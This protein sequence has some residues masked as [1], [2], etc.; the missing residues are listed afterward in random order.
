[1]TAATVTGSFDLSLLSLDE[2]LAGI[3]S[4][5]GLKA[6]GLGVTEG[7][8]VP[9]V[10]KV[11][12]PRVDQVAV[13]MDAA[14]NR[15][16]LPLV[17]R[18]E[19]RRRAM[20]AAAADSVR[21]SEAAWSNEGWEEYT[22][23][24]YRTNIVAL[25]A[26]NCI[27][28]YHD[29]NV[30]HYE[31]DSIVHEFDEFIMLKDFLQ[32]SAAPKFEAGCHVFAEYFATLA[33][34]GVAG[35]INW[36]RAGHHLGV[37]CTAGVPL[38][39]SWAGK[40]LERFMAATSATT[41]FRQHA[42]D[43]LWSACHVWPTHGIWGAIAATKFEGKNLADVSM[44]LTFIGL[45]GPSYAVDRGVVRRGV[46]TMNFSAEIGMRAFS[47]GEGNAVV[48]MAATLLPVLVNQRAIAALPNAAEL[49]DL[50]K[51]VGRA[52]ERFLHF[53]KGSSYLTGVP[54]KKIEVDI[55]DQLFVDLAYWISKQNSSSTLRRSALFMKY[56][57]RKDEVSDG[58]RAFTDSLFRM[59]E[60]GAA[61]ALS[62]QM[63]NLLVAAPA[64]KLASS[65][66][67]A[68][69]NGTPWEN[70]GQEIDEVLAQPV[71]AGSLVRGGAFTAGAPTQQRRPQ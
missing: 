38:E 42:R 14:M 39:K 26:Y 69:L 17:N 61:R 10:Y 43:H 4:E 64:Q 24:F 57:P 12:V 54:E 50:W 18:P 9:D 35:K 8:G 7:R 2:C 11:H 66:F 29:G 67:H 63:N 47:L 70:Q 22:K 48:S 21:L 59:R 19:Y 28:R 16:N 58:W 55:Y 6:I 53:F 36:F 56:D 71:T 33:C 23:T 49:V 3:L 31:Q 41:Q 46:Q 34:L 52:K 65:G 1:M 37:L 51:E 15:L 13:E 68:L 60:T 45:A 30:F 5:N 25:F 40:L 20:L 27:G 44:P 62:G 32:N